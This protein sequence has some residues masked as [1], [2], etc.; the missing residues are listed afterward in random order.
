MSICFNVYLGRANV[1]D[2]QL[3]DDYITPG[4]MADTDSSDFTQIDV[5]VDGTA[6]SSEDYP[7]LI[8]WNDT[9]R[10]LVKLGLLPLPIG[11]WRSCFIVYD[12]L[13]PEGIHWEPDFEVNVLED[14]DEG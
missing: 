12:A 9:G 11:K 13:T 3:Q 1:E 10:L 2:L 14:L 4:T 7:T 6:Y 5:I 8:T